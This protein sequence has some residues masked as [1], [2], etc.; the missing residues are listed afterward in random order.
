MRSEFIALCDGDRN[1]A[2]ILD[3]FCQCR[4]THD[5]CEHF[6][7]WST[8]YRKSEY[9]YQPADPDIIVQNTGGILTRRE[10]IDA[11]N[12]LLRLRL[13]GLNPLDKSEVTLNVK[14]LNLSFQRDFLACQKQ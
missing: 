4:V 3:Y 13:L 11:M 12:A 7:S 2:L 6:E 8:G 10:I 5:E 1:A 9:Y 14:Q